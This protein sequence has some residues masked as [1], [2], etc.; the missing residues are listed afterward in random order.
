MLKTALVLLVKFALL[1]VLFVALYM[2][3]S[4]VFSARMAQTPPPDQQPQILLG[5]F[6]VALVDTV[7]ISLVI[8]CSLWSGVRLTLATIFAWYGTMT[9][10]TQIESAW[11][12]PSLGIGSDMLPALFLGSVPLV[13]IF[14][15]VAVFIWG[16]WRPTPDRTDGGRLP[17]TAMEWLWKLAVIAVLYVTL[18]FAF[19]Y[20]V[21]WQNPALREMYGNGA[22]QKVF[23]L[24]RL[25]PFQV[26]RSMLWVLFTLPVVRMTRGPVWSAAVVVGLL[27]ALPP[28][29]VLVIPFNPIMPDPSVRL[30]HLVETTASDF[31][32][33]VCL[34]FLLQWQPALTTRGASELAKP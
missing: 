28:T 16:K 24:A 8:V 30:S 4:A 26:V 12:G 25:L 15:P 34:T 7:V 6:L 17:Q 2:L 9:F 21:A 29:I 33:G 10:M 13:L 14:S 22:N 5:L 31:I 20:V 19:G 27:L 3:G 23:D 11:F 18:Y 1:C 32:Y